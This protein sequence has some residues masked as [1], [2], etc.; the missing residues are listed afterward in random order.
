MCRNTVL[1]VDVVSRW[2]MQQI[3]LTDLGFQFVA[4]V[5]VALSPRMTSSNELTQF[6]DFLPAV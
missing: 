1:Y 5:L 6:L 4:R 3:F 2:F